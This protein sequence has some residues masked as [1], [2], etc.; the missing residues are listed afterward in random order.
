MSAY[1]IQRFAVISTGHVSEE[2]SKSLRDTPVEDWPFLGGP[3]GDYGWFFYAH[4]ENGG[5]GKDAIPDDL[6]AVMTWARELGCS[7]LLL[8]CDGD[9]VDELPHYDW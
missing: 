4:D 2:T 1:E 8:D 5:T 7:Y 9:T 6:F 3:Y